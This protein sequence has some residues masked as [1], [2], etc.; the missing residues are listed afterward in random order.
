MKT[1]E[2]PCE[3]YMWEGECS[4]GHQGTFRKACQHC[5]FYKPKP[6]SFPRR[7]DLRQQKEERWQKKQE[8]NWYY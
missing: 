2:K 5:N 6:G 1:R 3:S 8:K 4:K 7:T